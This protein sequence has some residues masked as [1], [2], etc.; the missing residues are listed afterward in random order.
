M[1][2]IR[3]L[4]D[5][6]LV[7]GMKSENDKQKKQTANKTSAKNSNFEGIET[8]QTERKKESKKEKKWK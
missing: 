3:F 1:L 5:S 7:S 8:R 4:V 2:Y 6:W